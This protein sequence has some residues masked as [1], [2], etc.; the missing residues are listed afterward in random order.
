MFYTASN[1]LFE[2]YA[3]WFTAS[4]DYSSLTIEPGCLP[5]SV[6][7]CGETN[8]I[9]DGYY[10][11]HAD[12]EYKRFYDEAQ[13]KFYFKSGYSEYTFKYLWYDADRYNWVVSK[14]PFNR[15]TAV[16]YRHKIDLEGSDWFVIGNGTFETCDPDTTSCD[17]LFTDQKI[18]VSQTECPDE[19]VDPTA[20][21]MSMHARIRNGFILP[22][23][24]TTFGKVSEGVSQAFGHQVK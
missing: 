15:V 11:Q 21:I 8:L 24:K 23:Q 10:S 17:W 19:Y 4:G 12:G 6:Y 18:T 14:E 22:D 2:Q 3:Q 16:M 5:N 13:N 1:D 7:I 9:A 20:H